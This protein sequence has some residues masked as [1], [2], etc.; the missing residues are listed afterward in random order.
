MSSQSRRLR[1]SSRPIHWAAATKVSKK[2]EKP[3]K[4]E[5]LFILNPERTPPKG[6]NTQVAEFFGGKGL[7]P[8]DA[9]D[10]IMKSDF[11][12]PK[13]KLFKNDTEKRVYLKGYISHLV[14]RKF[15][16]EKSA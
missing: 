12:P 9:L 16:V 6:I 13:S 4:P 7:R 1:C 11:E 5:A 15:L 2:V 8:T 10:A 14:G 3:A